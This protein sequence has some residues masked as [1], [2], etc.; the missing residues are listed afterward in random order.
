MTRAEILSA[1]RALSE[2]YGAAP[3]AGSEQTTKTT[4]PN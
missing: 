1:T 4:I 3:E 2:D